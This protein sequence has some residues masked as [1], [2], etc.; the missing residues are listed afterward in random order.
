MN[1][2]DQ[3]LLQRLFSRVPVG[4]LAV[5]VDGAP[6]TGLLPYVYD[7]TSQAL[8]ILASDLAKHAAGL[9][10]D[11]PYSF[12]IHDRSDPDGNAFEV[13]RVSVQG[14]VHV[15]DRQSEAFA[16]ALRA[17]LTRFPEQRALTE[18]RDFNFYQLSIESGR[19]IAGFGRTFNLTAGSIRAAVIA[20]T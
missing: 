17:F 13:P 16:E 19:F 18:F 2:Q 4:T 7:R 20:Q 1:L 6:V 15:V 12:L 9:Q 11:A 8:L 10:D 3:Q 14:L 5:L